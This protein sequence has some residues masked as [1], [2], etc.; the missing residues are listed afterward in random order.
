MTAFLSMWLSNTATAAMMAPLASA[1]ME[2]L[3]R[4]KTPRPPPVRE[5]LE[6]EDD[7][8]MRDI[9]EA[10]AAARGTGEAAGGGG[11][12]EVSGRGEAPI[13]V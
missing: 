9:R 13:R 2:T 7:G 12:G 3:T 10:L 1:V 11:Q 8:Q 4:K 5:G 6:G